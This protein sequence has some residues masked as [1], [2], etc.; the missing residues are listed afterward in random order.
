MENEKPTIT[1]TTRDASETLI[2]NND[3]AP[4][5]PKPTKGATNGTLDTP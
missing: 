4:A 5:S 3:P 1:I 2:I